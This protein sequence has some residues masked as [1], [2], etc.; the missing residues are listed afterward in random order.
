[1]LSHYF[2]YFSQCSSAWFCSRL[3]DMFCVAVS[4]NNFSAMAWTSYSSCLT[5]DTTL[6]LTQD[7]EY[8]QIIRSLW[9]NENSE[10]SLQLYCPDIPNYSHWELAISLGLCVSKEQNVEKRRF[11]SSRKLEYSISC[12]S[13]AEE[14][15]TLCVC[16][17]P[18]VVCGRGPTFTGCILWL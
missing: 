17:F 11:F 15:Y 18:A 4:S 5:L 1:M 13:F 6:V 9:Q 8:C 14:K 12:L 2:Y 16:L 3:I 7:W 10:S